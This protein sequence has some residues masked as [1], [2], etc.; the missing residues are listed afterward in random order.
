MIPLWFTRINSAGALLAGRGQY[1]TVKNGMRY[2][3]AVGI[4][5][6]SCRADMGAGR[7]TAR[8]RSRTRGAVLGQRDRGRAEVG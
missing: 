7:D 5:I 1:S 3:S 4:L 6:S 2:G 8:T